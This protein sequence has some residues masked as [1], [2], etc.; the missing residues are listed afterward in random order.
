MT[1]KRVLFVLDYIKK[2][3]VKEDKATGAV[4][5]TFFDTEE[6]KWYKKEIRNAFTAMGLQDSVEYIVTYAYP[7]IPAIIKDNPK[8]PARIKY[9]APTVKDFTEYKEFYINKIIELDPDIIVPLGGGGIKPF[10]NT[11]A[12]SKVQG[13]PQEIEVKERLTQ[14]LKYWFYPSYSP[15]YAQVKPDIMTYVQK[16]LRK[17]GDFLVRGEDAFTVT[18]K[19]YP[20][21]DNDFDKVVAI[22]R[23]ALKHGKSY[24]DPVAFDYE[25]N[26]L[27]AEYEG[28][29][30]LTISLTWDGQPGVT[31]PLNH[32]E[33]PW[34]PDQQKKL[35]QLVKLFLDSDLWK[36]GHNVKFDMRQSKF[37]IDKD[38][39]FKNT[40]D[41]E[42]GYFLGVS[43]TENKGLK[44]VAYEFT[45]MGGYEAPL[46]EYK[47]WFLG[48][49]KTVYK[50]RNNEE[51]L[52][53]EDYLPNLSESDRDV[54]LDWANKLLDMYGKPNDVRNPADGE[55]FSYEWIPFDILS[56]YAA[57][58]TDVTYQINKGLLE[59]YLEQKPRLLNLYTVHYPMLIDALVD[60]EVFGVQL[61]VSRMEEMK[62]NFDTQ[63]N[64]LEEELSKD[65]LVQKVV[66][67]KEELY[68]QGL[69]EKAKKPAD[70]DPEIYKYYNKYRGV[71]G[72][73]FNSGSKD[74][75]QLVLFGYSGIMPPVE[76][77]FLTKKGKDLLASN[78]GDTSQINYSHFSTGKAVIDWLE[79]NYPDF[80][81]VQTLQK[82]SKVEKLRTSFTQKLID[83]SD[84]KDVIHGEF[85]PDRTATSRL[86][87]KNPN[88]QQLPREVNDPRQADYNNQIKTAFVP[89]YEHNQDTII[90]IDYSSQEA[91]LAA[92]IADD[93]DMIGSFVNGEDVHKA[94]AALMEDI[95][96]DEVTKDQRTAAKKLTFGLMYGKS[97]MGYADEMGITQEEAEEKFKMYFKGKPK[98]KQSIDD[99]Q[100][101][102][103]ENGYIEVPLGGFQRKAE[104][105]WSSDYS[106][107]SGALR[108]AFN[109]WVQGG[110]SYISTMAVIYVNRWLKQSK[111]NANLMLTVHDS[112]TISSSF[113]DAPAVAY[114]AK[115][116]MTHLPIKELQE[117]TYKGEKVD[118]FMDAEIGFGRSYGFEAEVSIDELKSF[119]SIDG[120]YDYYYAQ[121]LLRDKH[122]NHMMSDED[123]EASIKE[124]EG[125]KEFYQKITK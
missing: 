82:M 69:E 90:N 52:A 36:V 97:E 63:A 43:Q 48:F 76:D 35:N 10:F 70:R 71:D 38:I 77:R 60:M 28:S 78:G 91:H 18:Y 72:T 108:T 113:E 105:I 23:E 49:L 103:K 89:N 7:Q 45:D 85:M 54:A 50:V 42:I 114:G 115:Y 67:H 1:K 116:I 118:G 40:M 66:E 104:E 100:N 84:D 124:L 79:K 29:K 14:Y 65:E 32:P 99:A 59:R 57:G 22:F 3:Y 92:V 4:I 64:E 37:L 25:T 75:M 83:M 31:I 51:G 86:A 44:K 24:N 17:I 61:D 19:D 55:K 73:K 96:Y 101:F 74:D 5:D 123:Y 112:I 26:S 98:I 107:R 39:T 12:I 58:D 106:K 56:K 110:S 20:V 13:Q 88:L 121:K 119:S 16:D 15:A 122:D 62:A 21:L 102:L 120:F 95:P 6:G 111:Y 109:T 125:K 30:I 47:D 81:L 2:N 33:R 80:K 41:T 87:S 117:V 53:D 68:E 93:Q 94:T 8:H 27:H 46:D 11:S 34:K 9:K